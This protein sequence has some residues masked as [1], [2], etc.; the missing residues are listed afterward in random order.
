MLARRQEVASGSALNPAMQSSISQVDLNEFARVNALA[1]GLPEDDLRRAAVDAMNDLIAINRNSVR[2][3]NSTAPAP[4]PL[5]ASIPAARKSG[6]SRPTTEPN[7]AKK[8]DTH[9]AIPIGQSLVL[10]LV[11]LDPQNL[12]GSWLKADPRRSRATWVGGTTK[13]LQWEYDGNAYTLTGLV[14]EIWRQA[15]GTK[16]PSLRGPLYWVVPG[17]GSVASIAAKLP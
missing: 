6:N 9:K 15:S 17:R 7:A 16:P 14:K 2:H 8:I 1:N 4:V 12:L 11:N 13:V 5:T 3:S 10:D